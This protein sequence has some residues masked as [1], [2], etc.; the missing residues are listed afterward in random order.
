MLKWNYLV[1]NIIEG[2]IKARERK[3]LIDT[4]EGSS[5]SNSTM[6]RDTWNRMKW[7][8]MFR[9]GCKSYTCC[10]AEDYKCS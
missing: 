4:K 6:K 5:F 2:E 10:K 1:G 8:H 7:N 3:E 9:S